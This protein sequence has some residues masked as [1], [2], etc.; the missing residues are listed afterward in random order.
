MRQ[1][2]T[3][4]ERNGKSFW[5]KV[6]AAFSNKDGSESLY[7]DALPVNGRLQVRLSEGRNGSE[8]HDG[9]KQ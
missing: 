7:L 3:I 9:E 6:G 4:V 5:V 1:V 2:F 8:G